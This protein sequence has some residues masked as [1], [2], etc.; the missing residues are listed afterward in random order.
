MTWLGA[1]GGST[2]SADPSLFLQYGVVGLVAALA[3]YAAINLYKRLLGEY[4]REKQRA[5]RL[6]DELRKLND[7]I[8]EQTMQALNSATNAVTE[9]IQTLTDVKRR[10]PR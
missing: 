5:D 3:I 1:A 2:T 7:T 10:G 9:A 6:E 4:D 8:Q